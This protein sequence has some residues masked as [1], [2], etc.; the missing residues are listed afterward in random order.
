MKLGFLYA[1][2][3]LERLQELAKDPHAVPSDFFYGALELAAEGHEIFY[4]E[5]REERASKLL[6]W[7]DSLWGLRFAVRFSAAHFFS[8]LSHLKKWNSCD[9][10]VATNSRAGMSLGLLRKLGWLRAPVAAIHCGIVNHAQITSR[11][12]ATEPLLREQEIILFAESERPS[13]QEL[14]A[15][16]TDHFHICNFGVDTAFWNAG[17]EL[18]EFAFAVGNDSRRDFETFAKAAS[19]SPHPH[20][21]LT[22]IPLKTPPPPN[23]EHIRSAWCNA[24]IS[25]A[26]LR[27]IY[28]HSRCVVV[29][30]EDSLQPAGQSVTLQAMACARPVIM[31]RT[32]GY[33]LHPDFEDGR[34]LF[35]V[36]PGDTDALAQKIRCLMENPAE[37]QRMGQSGREMMLRHYSIQ[38]FADGVKS[39]CMAAIQKNH[40]S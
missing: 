23:L 7:I 11:L 6:H 18:G 2:G 36:V 29:P 40:H 9:C 31:T 37:A 12:K 34:H 35:L 15:V 30:L 33:W 3:R 32:R 24:A 20:K 25:D 22:R 26:D 16:P 28:T 5:I 10:V 17:A 1:G 38:H 39:A 21:L 19:L 4:D 14:F 13:M 8:C 27:E